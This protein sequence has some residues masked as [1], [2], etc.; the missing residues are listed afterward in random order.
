MKL[1]VIMQG[2][3][4]SGKSYFA[5]WLFENMR[6]LLS[7]VEWYSA[8][9]LRMQDGKYVYD[10]SKDAEIHAVCQRD[11]REAMEEGCPLVIIDNTNTRAWECKPYVEAGLANNYAIYFVGASGEFGN[12]HG[13]PAEKVSW[14]RDNAQRLTIQGCLN[15]ET[16]AEYRQRKEAEFRK[17]YE[18]LCN[19]HGL[20]FVLNSDDLIQTAKVKEKR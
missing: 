7:G 14:M 15:S 5:K 18:A 20:H 10:R 19:K 3:P 2:P 17:E 12:I 11:A 4:G 1:L 16:P 6:K 9:D 8:D 13:V